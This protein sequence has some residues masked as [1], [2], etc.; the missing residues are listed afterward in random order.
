MDREH[1]QG[2]GGRA[3][4]RCP[5]PSGCCGRF[6]IG[7]AEGIASSASMTLEPPIPNPSNGHLQIRFTL[8][9]A[10]ST[11]TAVV[12]VRGRVVWHHDEFASA[13]G[14]YSV[15]WNGSI[16]SGEPAPAGVYFATVASHGTVRSRRFVLIK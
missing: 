15:A 9:R 8:P 10:A 16:Q 12:D 5:V 14:E 2:D 4:D 1:D 7:S 13:P 3:P 11:T 6:R